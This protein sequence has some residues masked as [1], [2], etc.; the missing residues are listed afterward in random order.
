[1]KL[2]NAVNR[3]ILEAYDTLTTVEKSIADYF[4]GNQ[5]KG[6]FSSKTIANKLFVSEASLSRFAKKCGFKGFREFI[7]DYARALRKDESPISHSTEMVLE[8]YREM[9]ERNRALVKEEQ[10]IRVEKMLTQCRRI[11]VYGK[12]SSGYAAEEFSLRLMRMGMDIEAITDTHVMKMSGAL[13]GPDTLVMAI[14]ISGETPEI[15]TAIKYAHRNGA[16]VILV[17]ANHDSELAAQSDEV[18]YVA[19]MKKLDEG[20]LI[21]PQIPVLIMID[22][23]FTCFF[24]T[25]SGQRMRS[26]TESLEALHDIQKGSLSST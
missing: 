7:Y 20:M 2:E 18:I 6:D 14:T 25:D 11:K 22:I 15:L 26:F 19:T 13:V 5:D 10:I 16:K 12:G 24:Q 1:M 23:L 21:S 8:A 3:R 4:V 9:A 17:T